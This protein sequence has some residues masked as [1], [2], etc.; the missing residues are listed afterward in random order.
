MESEGAGGG[1]HRQLKA[2]NGVYL[3]SFCGTHTTMAFPHF[4]TTVRGFAVLFAYLSLLLGL[5][6]ISCPSPLP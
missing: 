5:F 1:N 6:G 3:Q 2:A 4:W